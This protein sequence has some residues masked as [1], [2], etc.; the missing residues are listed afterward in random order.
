MKIE[1]EGLYF[2]TAESDEGPGIDVPN[3]PASM[4]FHE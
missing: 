3:L 2:F 1:E 4:L